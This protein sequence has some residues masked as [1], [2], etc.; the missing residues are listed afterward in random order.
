MSTPSR[1]REV[2]QLGIGQSVLKSLLFSLEEKHR[3]D[4]DNQCVAD[5]VLDDLTIYTS[6]TA[7]EYGESNTIISLLI[8]DFKYEKNLFTRKCFL[9]NRIYPTRYKSKINKL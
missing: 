8:K 5:V 4:L 6:V 3:V 2:A 1:H 9:L 7:K